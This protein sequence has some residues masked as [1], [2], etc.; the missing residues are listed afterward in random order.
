MCFTHIWKL[1]NEFFNQNFRQIFHMLSVYYLYWPLTYIGL[2]IQQSKIQW[3]QH[4]K[5]TSWQSDK[6]AIRFATWWD[7]AYLMSSWSLTLFKIVA[8]TIHI[9]QWKWNPDWH[10]EFI[11][12]F[13]LLP[14]CSYNKWNEIRNE[15]KSKA[16]WCICAQNICWWHSIQNPFLLFPLLSLLLCVVLFGMRLSISL[17][18]ILSHKRQS[19]EKKKNKKNFSVSCE[20]F[21]F[22]PPLQII[23]F[24]LI[25]ISFHDTNWFLFSGIR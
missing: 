14:F 3:Q 18:L 11:Q 2:G 15:L 8:L 21:S 17:H 7:I 20:M 10:K 1:T 9:Y 6:N 5:K 23:G 25:L 4:G 16:I 12:V 24:G 13:K 19:N 22:S